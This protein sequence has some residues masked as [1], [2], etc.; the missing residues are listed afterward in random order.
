MRYNTRNPIGTDGSVD[1]RDFHDN[2]ANADLALN[3][4]ENS[5][6]DRLGK[7]RKTFKGMESDFASQQIALR[8]EF[9]QFLS[10]SGYVFIGDYEPGLEFTLRN[11]YMIKDGVAYRVAV[12]TELPYVTSGN[13][14]AEQS[15]FVAFSADDTLRQ[16]LASSLDGEG[17]S[18]V[19]IRK[20]S[21]TYGTVQE[22][23]ND[24]SGSYAVSAGNLYLSSFFRNNT[25]TSISLYAS[26]DGANFSRI[27]SPMTTN[28][29]SF[30]G[31]DPSIYYKD[32]TFYI[33]VTNYQAGSHDFAVWKSKDLVSWSI[34]Y[35]N[36]GSSPVCSNTTSAPG[37]SVPCN[38]IWAP[39]WFE[40]DDDLYILISLR[41][42]ADAA[43][44]NGLIVPFFRPFYSKCTSLEDMQFDAPIEIAIQGDAGNKID[45]A[46]I[47]VGSTLHMAIK[48]EYDKY[49]YLYSSGSIDGAWTLEGKIPV[50]GVE[51]PCIT[52][53]NN[54]YRI[55]FDHFELGATAFVDTDN[56]SVF[57]GQRFINATS[58][59]RHGTVISV[60]E[61]PEFDQNYIRSRIAGVSS[62]A[63]QGLH[64]SSP[65]LNLVSGNVSITPYEG[66]IYS[67]SGTNVVN[68]EILSQTANEFFLQVRSDSA[69]AAILI[70]AQSNYA[71]GDGSLD[72]V[73]YG[74]Y[75]NR[76]IRIRRDSQDGKYRA[77][78]IQGT[79]GIGSGAGLVSD[80]GSKDINNGSVTWT[81][82]FGWT[83]TTSG[84]DAGEVV[85][86]SLPSLPEGF[87]FNLMVLSGTADGAIRIKSGGFSIGGRDALYRGDFGYDGKIIRIVRA[88]SA[89]RVEGGTELCESV[90]YDPPS[91]AAN[92]EI[93]T[94]IPVAGAAMGDFVQVAF[95][96][97]VGVIELDAYV[98]SSGVVTVRLRNR[99]GAA[100]DLNAGVLRVRVTR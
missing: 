53:V 32:G 28:G 33:A 72:I 98:S 15:K 97:S 57:T 35:A 42:A 88:A 60:S 3:S 46:I 90:A 37:G 16:D 64:D 96:Q 68:L 77:E 1:P 43:D 52:K 62:F 91:I 66:A 25:D 49:I 54:S 84:S 4:E 7:A 65:R 74:N 71:P 83:Y 8:E 10:A 82:K 23:A 2:V 55:Y 78:G 67:V 13:W 76:L 6:V 48:N 36:L 44:V 17:A 27:V 58:L 34:H 14:A 56:F 24:L 47:A 93:T 100:I 41:Y 80:A 94:T 61:Y 86:N 87:T 89:W 73:G 30:S 5:W 26:L 12:S 95:S 18:L 9:L 29:D 63:Y 92:S 19:S 59:H 79:R 22:M 70:P 38:R 39:E 81:P 99:S 51:G 45:P 75:R 11:Q 69:S 50:Y 20:P 85:I 40:H 31:R 21:G